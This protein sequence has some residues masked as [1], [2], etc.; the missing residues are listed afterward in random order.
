GY[1]SQDGI[2]VFD[3]DKYQRYNFR[4]N[5]NANLSDRLKV[6]T[7]FQL[8]NTRQDKMSSKGDAP[9]I[10]RHAFIRPPVIPVYKDVND[11]TYSENDPYTDL[12]FYKHNNQSGGGWDNKYEYTS[13][14]VALAKFTNDQRNSFR[15]F[16]N[17]YAEYAFL[18]NNDLK[19]RTNLG[20]DLNMS[21]NKT[22]NENFGD[23]DGGGG[24]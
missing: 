19:F 21:H 1:Y 12:P 8:S 13:N 10:I 17:V 22:F 14:P 9:G 24:D 3:N 20:V 23:D 4:T 18:K 16:G 11:P 7:N 15:L 2:V 5:I 6:G